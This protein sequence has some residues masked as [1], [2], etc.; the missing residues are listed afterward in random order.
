M[1]FRILRY[2]RNRSQNLVLTG[3]CSH[4][5]YFIYLFFFYYYFLLFFIYFCCWY[6]NFFF[7]VIFWYFIIFLFFFYIE[8]TFYGELFVMFTILQFLIP[9]FYEFVIRFDEKFNL[10]LNIPTWALKR[11]FIVWQ[12][13]IHVHVILDELCC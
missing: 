8:A 4:Y 12:W 9:L 5:Y 6:F 13:N 7:I 3:S 11:H 1:T 2:R 10:Q